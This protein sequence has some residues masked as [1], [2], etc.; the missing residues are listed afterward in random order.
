MG[1]LCA[2]HGVVLVRSCAV[3]KVRGV[4]LPVESALGDGHDESGLDFADLN[5]GVSLP[6]DARNDGSTDH[7]DHASNDTDRDGLYRSFD[8]LSACHSLFRHRN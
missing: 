8:P 7:A 3:Q 4:V 2:D 5:Q 1:A 6:D